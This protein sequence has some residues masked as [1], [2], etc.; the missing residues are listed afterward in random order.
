MGK[1]WKKTLKKVGKAVR[2]VASDVVGVY[3]GGAVNFRTK[4]KKSHDAGY[5]SEAAGQISR[6]VSSQ[7]GAGQINYT[8]ET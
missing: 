4:K 2:N 7:A 8:D 3:T 6:S 1:G 5:T